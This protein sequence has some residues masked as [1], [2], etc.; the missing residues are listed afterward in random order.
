MPLA[1]SLCLSL[2]IL[3]ILAGAIGRARYADDSLKAITT[4]QSVQG[5][6]SGSDADIAVRVLIVL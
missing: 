4:A 6:R 5:N 1:V 3:F 2:T